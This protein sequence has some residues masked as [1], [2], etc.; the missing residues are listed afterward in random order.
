M[1]HTASDRLTSRSHRL[2][3]WLGYLLIAAVALRRRYDLADNF[4]LSLMLSLLGLFMVLY[5]SASLLFKMGR[6]YHRFYFAA[7]RTRSR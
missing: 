2:V 3:Y 7:W 6:N 5:T 4:D 1:D